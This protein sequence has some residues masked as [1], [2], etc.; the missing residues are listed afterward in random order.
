[1]HDNDD[2]RTIREKMYGFCF[3]N[4]IK[5]ISIVS[6]I[7][8]LIVVI[9]FLCLNKGG[10]IIVFMFPFSIIFFLLDLYYYK[11]WSCGTTGALL[12]MLLSIISFILGFFLKS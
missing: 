1:M 11:Y 8:L 7:A 3:K 6:I 9:S 4:R 10:F 12:L 2:Y 5:I